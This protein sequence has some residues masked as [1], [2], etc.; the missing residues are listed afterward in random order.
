[1]TLH[2]HLRFVAHTTTTVSSR[3]VVGNYLLST[4][5]CDWHLFR[6]LTLHDHQTLRARPARTR[7]RAP[8]T[9]LNGGSGLVLLAPEASRAERI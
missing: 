4:V 2:R 3:I 6:S 8:T 5:L 9:N 1:M 7:K